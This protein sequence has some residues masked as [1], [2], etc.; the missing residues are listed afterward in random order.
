MLRLPRAVKATGITVEMK[1]ARANLL[2]EIQS[3]GIMKEA[4]SQKEIK[5]EEWIV[6]KG[7]TVQVKLVAKE[8]NTCEIGFYLNNEK[9]GTYTIENLTA[10]SI[11]PCADVSGVS[12]VRGDTK[13][14]F[15]M[16]SSRFK[17][18]IADE[19]RFRK[20]SYVE[21]E[22]RI[23]P[24]RQVAQQTEDTDIENFIAPASIV[25]VNEMGDLLVRF[26]TGEEFWTE[27]FSEFIHPCGYW[28]YLKG[29]NEKRNERLNGLF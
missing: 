18:E 6:K 10:C 17:S 23:D 9:I 5:S 2:K 4:K 14:F 7:D 3:L 12:E 24:S 19:Y 26:E 13:V 16:S 25:D 29:A 20:G 21:A 27:P 11:Y 15:D 8:L 28:M 1:T 22:S